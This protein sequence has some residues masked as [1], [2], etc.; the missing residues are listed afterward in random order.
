M[1]ALCKWKTH[2][3]ISRYKSLV[4]ISLKTDYCTPKIMAVDTY[5]KDRKISMHIDKPFEETLADFEICAVILRL[6]D[7]Q[8]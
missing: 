8:R 5:F 2:S 7:T 4:R 1:A 3:I 6:I